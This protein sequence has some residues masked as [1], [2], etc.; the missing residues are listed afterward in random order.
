MEQELPEAGVGHSGTPGTAKGAFHA[1]MVTKYPGLGQFWRPTALGKM[2]QIVWRWEGG[3][4]VPWGRM[5]ILSLTREQHKGKPRKELKQQMGEHNVLHSFSIKFQKC[6]SFRPCLRWHCKELSTDSS[7]SFSNTPA[8]PPNPASRKR[9]WENVE[10]SQQEPSALTFI[11]CM[12]IT[13]TQIITFNRVSPSKW[14]LF[15]TVRKHSLHGEKGMEGRMRAM[16]TA[17]STADT[18]QERNH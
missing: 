14:D 11:G 17:N 10:N 18:C 4:D 15:I 7:A 2:Q 12:D 3:W 6:T 5:N 16:L 13:T 9:T 1:L 8:H